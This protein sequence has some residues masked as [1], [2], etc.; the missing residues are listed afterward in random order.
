MIVIGG[1]W[2]GL[3]TAAILA[4]EGVDV[5]VLEAGRVPGG[6]ASYLEKDGFLVD[7]GI[8]A[9]RFGVEGAAAACYRRLGLELELVEPGPGL[10]RHR[11]KAYD[12]PDSPAGLARIRLLSLRQKAGVGRVLLRLLRTS[13]EALY[14]VPVSQKLSGK[15]D[16][17]A[18]YFL[19]V[20][21][22]MGL[23]SP[24][25]S[26]T[27]AGELASFLRSAMRAKEMLSFPRGGCRQHV[28]RLS[29]VISGAGEIRTGFRVRNLVMEGRSVAGV[30]GE[31]EV[32]RSKAVVAAV[33]L[34]AVAELV[35]EKTAGFPLKQKMSAMR[36]TSGLSWDVALKRPVSEYHSV[37]FTEPLILGAFNSNFDPTVCPAGKQFCTWFMPLPPGVFEEAGGPAGEEARLRKHVLST[38]D[39]M[40]ES[41]EWER[42]LRLGTVDGAAPLA[43]QPWPLRPAPD[44]SGI[45]NLFL[46]G[47]TVGVP[48]QGGDIAFRSAIDCADAVMSRLV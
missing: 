2:G 14:E 47:D 29:S 32:L 4:G 42:T 19:S 28:K 24:D 37:T 17:E 16:P 36:P 30:E 40:E 6:R 5:L 8:H 38:F 9:H 34:P 27:S 12:A 26:I 39:R 21:S 25:L 43:T 31:G 46:A 22:G 44:E 48:G 41:I 33:P 13:P 15:M 11:G 35:P 18:R 1:G 7:Y 10:I 45:E 3:A 20:I 23:I